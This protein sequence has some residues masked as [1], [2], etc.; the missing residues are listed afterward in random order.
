MFGSG[1]DFEK[2][3]VKRKF[4][5]REWP[6]FRYEMNWSCK[7]SLWNDRKNLKLVKERKNL[8]LA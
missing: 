2:D 3:M 1:D 7:S 6:N 4:S 8:K 5:K